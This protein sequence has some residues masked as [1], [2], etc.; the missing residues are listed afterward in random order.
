MDKISSKNVIRLVFDGRSA[1][2]PLV[3]NLTVECHAAV[4]ILGADTKNIDGLAFGQM[5]LQLP[6]DDVA[7]ERIKKY[8]DERNVIYEEVQE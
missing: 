6:E 1:F 7:C 3:S 8:L 5:L 4:N 2:E